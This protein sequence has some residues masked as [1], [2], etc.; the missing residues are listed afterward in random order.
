MAEERSQTGADEQ[1]RAPS[2]QEALLEVYERRT[3]SHSKEPQTE[4]DLN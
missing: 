1:R 4:N 2:I 3:K